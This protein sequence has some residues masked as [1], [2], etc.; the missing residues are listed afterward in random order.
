MVQAHI[1][2]IRTLLVQVERYNTIVTI[3]QFSEDAL[4]EMKANVKG[5]CDEMKDEITEIKNEV[6]SW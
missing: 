3:D 1:D 6:D 2:R 4:G 5:F